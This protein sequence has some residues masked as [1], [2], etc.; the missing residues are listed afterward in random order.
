MVTR[1]FSATRGQDKPA[2]PDL[3]DSVRW[4]L[5]DMTRCG[6]PGYMRP[7]Q[8]RDALPAAAYPLAPICKPLTEMVVV[9]D[10]DDDFRT[11][12]VELVEG[13]GYPAIGCATATE[14][15]EKAAS[16]MS[17]C[18][19]LDVKLPGLDGLAVQEWLNSSGIVLPV[20]F[21]SGIQDIATVVQ[22]MKSGALEFLQKPFG[23]MV[24]R[25]AVSGA[26]ALSRQRHCLQQSERMVRELISTLTPTELFVARM[27][28]KGYPTK[29]IAAEMQRS[30]NTVKIHRHRI[31]NKL[32]V[33]SVASVANIMRHAG[34]GEDAGAAAA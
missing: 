20:I 15:Q 26:V 22:G 23:E 2:R 28:S 14:L 10:D 25:R 9:V 27:I 16:I 21:M 34:L 13:L 8:A 11:E 12:L 29:L 5:S 6:Q 1:R 7:C 19:L 30:E 24:L 31:F 4:S 32:M 33:N 3:P 17:G 18:V